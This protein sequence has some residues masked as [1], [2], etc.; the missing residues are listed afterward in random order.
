MDSDSGAIVQVVDTGIGFYGVQNATFDPI[1]RRY[2]LDGSQD[3]LVINLAT[4]VTTSW[5]AGGLALC[6]FDPVTGLLYCMRNVLPSG[7]LFVFSFN[8][9]TGAI[10]QVADTGVKSRSS[11]PIFDPFTRRFVFAVS[12]DQLLVLDLATGSTSHVPSLGGL[13]FDPATRLVYGIRYMPASDSHAVFSLDLTS[14]A[15]TFIADIGLTSISGTMGYPTIDPVRRRYFLTVSSATDRVV[16]VD[17][18]T[19]VVT[20]FNDSLH[21]NKFDTGS[22]AFAI[23]SSIPVLNVSFLTT[24][25]ILLAFAGLW[26][27]AR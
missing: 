1:G 16:V 25:V 17:L 14:G 4:G 24:T 2:F 6:Q 27:T 26:R 7:N 21:H 23:A 3:L 10:A 13:V 15:T 20:H 9:N 18:V 22:N 19:G 12:D 5:Y 11:A 8:P